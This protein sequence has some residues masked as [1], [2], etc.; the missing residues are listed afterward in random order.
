MNTLSKMLSYSTIRLSIY[1]LL[2]EKF[3]IWKTS[4]A[5]FPLRQLNTASSFVLWEIKTNFQSSISDKNIWLRKNDHVLSK[6]SLEIVSI[7][8]VD[9]FKKKRPFL[10]HVYP[11]GNWLGKH[12]L[13]PPHP[14]QENLVFDE[15]ISED[16]VEQEVWFHS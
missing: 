11:N 3:F 15:I 1:F 16:D 14:Q 4:H 12:V 8:F 9:L 5:I 6:I 13:R 10:E 7:N 2:I